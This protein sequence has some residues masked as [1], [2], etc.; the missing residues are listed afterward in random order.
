M[1][2]VCNTE[3]WKNKESGE[4]VLVMSDY[5]CDRDICKPV[6]IFQAHYIPGQPWQV[7]DEDDFMEMYEKVEC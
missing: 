6:R 3:L 5:C 4:V 1:S 7:M 2:I